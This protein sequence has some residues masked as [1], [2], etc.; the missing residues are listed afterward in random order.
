MKKCVRFGCGC[1]IGAASASVLGIL[2][3]FVLAFALD[4]DASASEET[5]SVLVEDTFAPVAAAAAPAKMEREIV[6][7]VEYSFKAS[8][9][10]VTIVGLKK[11]ADA[12]PKRLVI[13]RMLG[14][15]KVKLIGDEA[16]CDD[17]SFMWNGQRMITPESSF[18]RSR[19]SGRLGFKV[20]VLPKGLES[21]GA[22][23]FYQCAD[24]VEVVIP[25]SVFDIGKEAFCGC[26][27]LKKVDI[28]SGMETIPRGLFKNTGLVAVE[29]P[30][31]VVQIEQEAFRDCKCLRT[32]KIPDHY[33][34]MFEFC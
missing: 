17:G 6:D 15:K 21:I 16:F 26:L 29:V 19:G 25:D 27:S 13:P 3:L 20:V 1:L 32:I 4:D 9:A 11:L 23:A 8:S 30:E 5:P 31:G 7:G 10:A 14:G 18:A 33:H 24:I 2:I 22:K 28:P 12:D 34:P